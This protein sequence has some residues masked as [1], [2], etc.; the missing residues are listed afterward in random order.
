MDKNLDNG[1]GER[2]PAEGM[3]SGVMS[4]ANEEQAVR[5]VRDVPVSGFARTDASPSMPGRPLGVWL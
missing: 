4:A 5:M 1:K 3:N 2:K